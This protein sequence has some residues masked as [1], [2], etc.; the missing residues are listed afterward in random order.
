MRME[1]IEAAIVIMMMFFIIYGAIVVFE[2]CDMVKELR[3]IRKHME[4]SSVG[5]KEK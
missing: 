3:E 5:Y 4:Q 2:L 1:N